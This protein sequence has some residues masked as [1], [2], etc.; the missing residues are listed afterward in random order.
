LNLSASSPLELRG[1]SGTCS[2]GTSV[3]CISA[4]F[5]AG[6][7]HILRGAS[8]SGKTALFRFTGL[9][10]PPAEGEVLMDGHATCGLGE[11]AR[12]ELRM[13]RLGFAF[14]APFLLSTFSVI[15][16]VAMPLFKI[17]RVDPEEAR[18]RTEAVLDFVGLPTAVEARVEELTVPAQYDVALA[19]GL[20][21]EP[22]A[23]LVEELD[24]VLSGSQLEEFVRL[25]RKAAVTFG[26]AIIA[27]ASPEL[28][29]QAGDRVLDID[30]GVVVRDSECLPEI[31]G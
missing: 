30:H 6:R 25:L 22:G 27:T 20:V 4:S 19:R 29:T 12:T 26:T 28:K 18:R 13:Q 5:A 1:V 21:N 7:L 10:E 14:A 9:L 3:N 2:D 15:E 16:N 11:D 31:C 24:G 8:G 23:L 17:S